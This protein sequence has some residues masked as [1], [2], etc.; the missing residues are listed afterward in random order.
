MEG[1]FHPWAMRRWR[2]RRRWHCCASSPWCV[3]PLCLVRAPMGTC[4]CRP[5]G[6]GG[7]PWAAPPPPGCSLKGD[8]LFPPGGCPQLPGRG[9]L[10]IDSS[11]PRGGSKRGLACFS[12]SRQVSSTPARSPK[13][14]G[15]SQAPHPRTLPN[16]R[17][18]HSVAKLSL[19]RSVEEG[20]CCVHSPYSVVV[21]SF[22]PPL[23]LPFTPLLP[24]WNPLSATD[25]YL[26]LLLRH[27]ATQNASVPR[28]NARQTPP[29]RRLPGTCLLPSL[30]ICTNAAYRK[31]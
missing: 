9:R 19:V 11:S 16:A 12:S 4:G 8:A 17:F 10:V 28:A 1:Y 25:P 13:A 24:Q 31:I 29:V 15:R 7:M 27:C 23:L 18:A 5:P 6:P 21:G 3:S 30:D 14:H 22:D 20:V 2:H 26:S